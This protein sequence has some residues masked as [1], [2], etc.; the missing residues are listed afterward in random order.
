MSYYLDMDKIKFTRSYSRTNGNNMWVCGDYVIVRNG[1][2]YWGYTGYELTFK[3][4]HLTLTDKFG[5]AVNEARLY[6]SKNNEN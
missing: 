3:G 4:M 5:Q 2:A 1:S 6:A